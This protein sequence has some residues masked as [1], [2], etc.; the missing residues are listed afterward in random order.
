MCR[1]ATSRNILL[2]AVLGVAPAAL[3]GQPAASPAASVELSWRHIGNAAVESG[4]PSLATGPVNRVWFGSADPS[5]LYASTPSGRIF[6]TKDLESWT[7]AT[8]VSVPAAANSPV[9]AAPEDGN[10]RILAVSGVRVY[11]A[12][13]NAHRSDDGGATW[14]DFTSLRGQSILGS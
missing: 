8:G 5:T 3:V 11:A 13:Q 2:L 7:L 10:Q 9:A 4:L 6:Q 12:G 1:D 14:T